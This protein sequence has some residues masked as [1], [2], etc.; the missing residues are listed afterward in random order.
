[1]AEAP[2]SVGD[3][4]ENPCPS[5]PYHCPP[6]SLCRIACTVQCDWVEKGGLRMNRKSKRMHERLTRGSGRGSAARACAHAAK[7]MEKRS[8]V[9]I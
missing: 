9:G 6:P 4:G 3:V 8:W 7:A 1:M 5:S 2:A